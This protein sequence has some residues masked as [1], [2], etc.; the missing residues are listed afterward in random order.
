MHFYLNCM[1]FHKKNKNK[2][3]KQAAL[4]AVSTTV[5]TTYLEGNFF[6]EAF[7]FGTFQPLSLPFHFPCWGSAGDGGQQLDGEARAAF[8]LPSAEGRR[9]KRCSRASKL[10]RT[11]THTLPICN[12]LSLT[13]SR[14]GRA[15]TRLCQAGM[16]AR[17]YPRCQAPA[18][19][20]QAS[21]SQPCE[22]APEPLRDLTH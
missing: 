19:P 18:A 3:N 13:H 14:L 7:K 9:Q 17:R 4:L 21:R 8:P 5:G 10:S 22:P 16:D 2:N 15:V 20:L 6:L 1:E 12:I 11:H